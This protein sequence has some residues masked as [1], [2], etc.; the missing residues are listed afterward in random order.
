MGRIVL[1][2][3]FVYSSTAKR[4]IKVLWKQEDSFTGTGSD[5]KGFSDW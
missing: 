4:D 5:V 3:K 1:G 2:L